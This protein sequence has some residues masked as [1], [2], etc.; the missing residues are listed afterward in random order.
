[1]PTH[2]LTRRNLAG[3]LVLDVVLFVLANVTINS[4]KHPGTLSN[5]CWVAF[6]IGAVLF[7]LL[8]LV[9]LVA[10]MRSRRVVKTA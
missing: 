6:L 1:M 10:S 9:A 4:N 5:V 3:L 7:V 8:A 2:L